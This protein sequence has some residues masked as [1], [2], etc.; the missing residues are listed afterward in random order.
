MILD[1][2]SSGDARLVTSRFVLASV[3]PFADSD[4]IFPPID[5]VH[6]GNL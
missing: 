2:Y 5:Y 3:F 6:A 4:D 1:Y